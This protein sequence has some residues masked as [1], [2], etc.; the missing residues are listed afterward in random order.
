MVILVVEDDPEARASLED[1]LRSEGYEV[2]CAEDGRKGMAYLKTADPLPRLILLDLLMPH[3]DGFHFR[4]QQLRSAHLA[5]IPVVVMTADGHVFD[6]MDTL[7][8]AAYVRKPVNTE[9]LLDLIRRL[10]PSQRA[11]VR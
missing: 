2:A 7:R 3:A 10:I 1:L 5:G 6:R 11:P 4:E 8:A 9:A